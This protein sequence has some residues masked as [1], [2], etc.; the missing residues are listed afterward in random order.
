MHRVLRLLQVVTSPPALPLT[1]I[2]YDDPDVLA[3]VAMNAGPIVL[4][5]TCAFVALTALMTERWARRPA[6]PRADGPLAGGLPVLGP[7]GDGR[8]VRVRSPR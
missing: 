7:D 1:S 3:L 2:I 8:S 4:G 5:S 6:A